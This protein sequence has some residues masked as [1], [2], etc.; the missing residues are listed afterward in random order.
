MA[1]TELIR[2][3]RSVFDKLLPGLKQKK[4]TS[5]NTRSEIKYFTLGDK[6]FHRMFK[7]GIEFWGDCITSK[8]VGRV[9]YKTSSI[10]SEHKRHINQLRHRFTDDVTAQ[11]EV[12][13]TVL[14]DIFEVSTPLTTEILVPRQNSK[15]KIKRV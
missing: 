2:K 3:V 14:Y 12:P 13:M 9:I 8:M 5:N 7:K 11:K 6:V 10:K 4:K 15:R 1:P